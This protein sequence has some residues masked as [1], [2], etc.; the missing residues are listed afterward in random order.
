M[1]GTGRFRSNSALR[2]D[3]D[4]RALIASLEYRFEN[5]PVDWENPPALGRSQK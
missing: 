2:G 5:G 3:D 1:L 4:Y